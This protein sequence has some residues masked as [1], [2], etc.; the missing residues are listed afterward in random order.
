MF[1]RYLA[2]KG[3]VVVVVVV[4]VPDCGSESD[5]CFLRKGGEGEVAFL[6]EETG[7]FCFFARPLTTI[8]VVME[9]K[10]K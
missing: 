9:R 2:S 5:R 3:N 6:P 4:V 10:S 7:F 1:L 8:S